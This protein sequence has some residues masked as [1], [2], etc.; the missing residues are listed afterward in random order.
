MAIPPGGRGRG[1]VVTILPHGD[2]F[3]GNVL[4]TVSQA[5]GHE[6]WRQGVQD[7]G[8]LH[9]HAVQLGAQVVPCDAVQAVLFVT[10]L[11]ETLP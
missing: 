7:V 4:Y 8:F 11:K 1:K 5:V 3:W 9:L 6:L 10:D 2:G